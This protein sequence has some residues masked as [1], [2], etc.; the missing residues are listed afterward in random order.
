MPTSMR[1]IFVKRFESK[2][3][4]EPNS[5]CWLWVA[6]YNR[7]GYGQMNVYGWMNINKPMTASRL[8]WMIYVG[9]PGSL[10]V[11]HKCDVKACV[12]PDHL[13]LGTKS[14][15]ARDALKRGQMATGFRLPH[16]RLSSKDINIIRLLGRLCI[17]NHVLAE[18]F[19]IS[20]SYVSRLLSGQRRI[21]DANCAI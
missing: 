21:V 2:F 13:Y 1:E 7:Y 17:P 15:N 16:T 3:I 14:D 11:L 8:S 12:N 5:G 19:G 4:P 9:D 20:R 18:E 10:S 6:S